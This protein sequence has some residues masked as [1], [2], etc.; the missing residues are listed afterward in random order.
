MTENQHHQR[1]VSMR[2]NLKIEVTSAALHIMA[3]VFMLCD[4]L[5]GTVLPGNEWM[6]CIGRLAFPIFAFMLVEGYFHTKNLKKYAIFCILELWAY[7]YQ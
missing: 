1:S 4:H 2:K 7:K 5:W 3:M 6:T